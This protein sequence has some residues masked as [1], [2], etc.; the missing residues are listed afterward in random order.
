MEVKVGDR[1]RCSYKNQVLYGRVDE[2]LYLGRMMA[3]VVT[4]DGQRINLPTK[5]LR[6]VKE[7]T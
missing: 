1:V 2:L 7:R 5:G 6:V 4:D 3:R